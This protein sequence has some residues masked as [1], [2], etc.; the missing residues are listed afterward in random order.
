VTSVSPQQ[1]TAWTNLVA[2]FDAG[3]V[4]S[5]LARE[6]VRQLGT[7]GVLA[8][9][10][11]H[12]KFRDLTAAREDL[13]AALRFGGH[14]SL[15]QLIAGELAAVLREPGV[16]LARLQVARMRDPRLAEKALDFELR[17]ARRWCWYRDTRAI[18]ARAIEEPALAQLA[19]SE[20]GQL[21]ED[22][23]LYERALE[24]AEAALP[25]TPTADQCLRHA[26]LAARTLRHERAIEMVETAVRNAPERDVL[27]QAVEVLVAV[28]AFDRAESLLRDAVDRDAADVAATARLAELLL[29]RGE[30]GAACELAERALQNDPSCSPALRINGIYEVHRQRGDEALGWFDRALAVQ[31]QDPETLAWRARCLLETETKHFDDSY[32][33]SAAYRA[34]LEASNIAHGFF[35]PAEL[36]RFQ[37][38]AAHM[39]HE[40]PNEADGRTGLTRQYVEPAIPFLRCIQPDAGDVL[41]SQDGPAQY[42]LLTKG[43]EALGANYSRSTT[44]C[45]NGRLERIA[46][47]SIRD[48]A[49][50]ALGTIRVLPVVE[51]QAEIARVIAEYPESSLPL[52][53]MGELCVWLGDVAA[54]RLWL[55]RAI[56]HTRTTRWAYIGL[57]AC[58]LLE[59]EYVKALDV[60]ALG[61]ERM[62]NTTG[63]AVYPHRAEALRLLGRFDEARADLRRALETS[64]GRISAWINLGLLEADIGNENALAAAFEHVRRRAA[65]LVADA[66]EEIREPAWLDQ[67][68]LPAATAQRRIL[69]RTLAMLRGNRA[70]GIVTYFR[71]DES[72]RVLTPADLE[73]SRYDDSDLRSV[74]ALIEDLSPGRRRSVRNPPHRRS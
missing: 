65:G 55:G 17:V 41:R 11:L 70:T 66:S 13:A 46:A 6:S 64:A 33:S 7:L 50:R 60:L 14:L 30:D 58:E 20:L 49:L 68:G 42:A 52:C 24:E 72:P 73:L 15:V 40:G 22:A 10:W 57:S 23:E 62:G 45:R 4:D 67:D 3:R 38:D 35:L 51:V 5:P 2:E 36:L 59:G 31:P 48:A 27:L 44:V 29:W 26:H 28:G 19:H 32:Q 56:E 69:E 21:F 8:R 71:A 9:A 25:S 1:V 39:L 63:A 34:V 61:V 53:Y 54:A 12:A 74:W 18:A 43:V 47:H 16:A 37:H